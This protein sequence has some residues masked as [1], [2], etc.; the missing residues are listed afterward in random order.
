MADKD[1]EVAVKITG[2]GASAVAAMKQASSAVTD[3]VDKM[4]GALNNVGE[5]FGK[6]TGL[7]AALT[8]IVAGGKFF[9][10][11]IAESN[12]LTGETMRLAK[13]LGITAEEATTLN[14]AL[15]DIYSDSDTYVGA[16][17]R[18][19]QQMRRNEDGMKA[20]GIQTRDAAG[21]LREGND[22]FQEAIKVVSSYKPGLDQTTAAQTLFG[23]S[24]DDVMK[25]QKLN[26]EVLEDAK[27]KNEELGLIITDQNV[28]ASK[29]YKAAMNDV[30]DV[31]TA[32][33]KLVGDAVMP[34]F[35]ELA[36]YLASTGPYVVSIFKG[37]LTGLMLVFRSLQAVVK[38][39]A[40]VIF[41]FI[42]TT[43]DQV[44]NLS[45]LISAVLSGD[46]DK[47]GD[48]AVRM[49]DRA[50]QSFH[51]IKDAAVDAFSTASDSFGGDLD[52]MWGPKQAAKAGG[53]KGTKRMGEFKDDK[54][55][56]DQQEKHL[57]MIEA[58]LAAEKLKYAQI[59]DLREMDKAAELAKYEEIA[60]KYPLTEQEKAKVAKKS[61]EM[62]LEVLREE[63]RQ[64]LALSEEAIEAYKQQQLDGLAAVRQDAQFR[65]DTQQMTQEELLKLDMQLED[66]RYQITREAV[67][68]RLALLEKDPTKNVVALQ[69]LNDELAQVEREHQLKQ[70]AAQQGLQKEQLKDWQTMFN[71]IGQTFGNV[72]VG[73]V[74]RTMTL[75]Q[76]VKGLLGSVLSSVSNFLAQMI[77]KRVAAWAVEKMIG[78]QQQA[79][80]AVTAGSGAAASQASIPYVGPALAIA[81][82]A[83]VFAA[84]MGLGGG[85]GG[86]SVP[87]AR[88]GFDIPSG[89][90]P[91]TQLHER[92]MVLPQEQADTIRA[93]GGSSQQPIL[94]ST[95]GGDFI[96]KNDLAQLLKKMNRNFKFL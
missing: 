90:N 88:G 43:I 72:V 10:D 37:A 14:T 45:E 92:E 28:E 35:T 54:G 8:A 82:M 15:G 93:M 33:M 20:M 53:G 85:G 42:N 83:A 96:H 76:A 32:V 47:A 34:A 89:M 75:G 65:V 11:A 4:K 95:T 27:K 61:A 46:F 58:E 79:S 80:N 19:A 52:R 81:A 38:T 77:A 74:T 30:G 55:G 17:Q 25:L 26:N 48:A 66:Q 68:A 21:N 2:D 67:Q 44:G 18:F 49:K 36:Q 70:R 50:I 64:T 56:K 59:N 31:M 7:F 63:R 71:S 91:M 3:G 73:L 6:L 39:V 57:A 51:N 62:R 16:F 23:K 41:E 87:S 86:S 13:T 94:I 9:K 84:V 12:K 40:S 24:I 78:T 1:Q 29:Q 22:V 5:A 60:A 69:K